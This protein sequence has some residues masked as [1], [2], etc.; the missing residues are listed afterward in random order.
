MCGSIRCM[1]FR[2]KHLREFRADRI[3]RGFNNV[4]HDTRGIL[5]ESDVDDFDMPPLNE[6]DFNGFVGIPPPFGMRDNA[7]NNDDELGTTSESSED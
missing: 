3:Q 7:D 6:D 5:N 4:P 1:I 2:K